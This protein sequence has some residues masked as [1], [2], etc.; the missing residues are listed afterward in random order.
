MSSSQEEGDWAMTMQS[1]PATRRSPLGLT[2]GVRVSPGAVARVHPDQMSS[3]QRRCRSVASLVSTPP[4]GPGSNTD[5]GIVYTPVPSNTSPRLYVN[6][7][8][9][10][11]DVYRVPST[12]R[13]PV[14]WSQFK[15]YR[16]D[17]PNLHHMS[18]TK[19][20]NNSKHPGM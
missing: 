20:E 9:F 13:L 7:G 8:G 4:P 2:P 3:A 12:I 19:Q 5:R 1:Q 11:V 10:S 15:E 6:V 14:L 18:Y 17:H 16:F